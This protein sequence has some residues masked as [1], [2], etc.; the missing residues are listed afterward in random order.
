MT[1]TVQEGHFV[2]T[3]SMVSMSFDINLEE[4]AHGVFAVEVSDDSEP[5]MV[6]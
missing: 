1:R 5:D 3:I 6:D 2:P 4:N